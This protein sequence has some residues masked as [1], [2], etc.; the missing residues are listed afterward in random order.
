MLAEKIARIL[1]RWRRGDPSEWHWAFRLFPV[2]AIDG[3][4]IGGHVMR[5]VINGREQFREE[6]RAEA[7][8]RIENEAW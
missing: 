1:E 7:I 5:R 8:K 2:A 6:T 3:K 4:M